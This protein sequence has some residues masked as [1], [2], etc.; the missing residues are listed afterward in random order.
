MTEKRVQRVKEPGQK[1]SLINQLAVLAQKC[2]ERRC[3]GGSE[4]ACDSGHTTPCI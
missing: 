2:A 1:A 4:V 3:K